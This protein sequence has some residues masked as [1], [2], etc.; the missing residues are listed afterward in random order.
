VIDRLTSEL[1]HLFC[2]TQTKSLPMGI[3]DS[4]ARRSLPCVVWVFA[5]R[6]FVDGQ[7]AIPAVSACNTHA[8]NQRCVFGA[9]H[10]F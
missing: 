9:D 4:L 2:R 1:W 8:S 7:R 10:A 6:W 3:T 5:V